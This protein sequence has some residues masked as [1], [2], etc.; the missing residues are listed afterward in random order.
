[1][2]WALD[3]RGLR[4][5]CWC[6]DDDDNEDFDDNAKD[7]EEEGSSIMVGVRVEEAEGSATVENGGG[8]P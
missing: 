8:G 1:M 6:C 5:C 7:D 2:R 4:K 3:A